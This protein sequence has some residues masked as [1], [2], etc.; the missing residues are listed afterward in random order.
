MAD[1]ILKLNGSADPGVMICQTFG[2][3]SP[4]SRRM[5]LALGAGVVV[6]ACSSDSSGSSSTD[7]P[8]TGVSDPSTP[9]TSA[10]TTAAPTT[11]PPAIELPSNPFTLG[12]ASGDPT[13]TAVILWT[14]L[15]LDPL[16]GGGMP[17]DDVDVTWEVSTTDDF[18]DVVASGTATATARHGHSVHVDAD[19]SAAGGREFH[20]RFRVG[21]HTSPTGRTLLA[22]AAGS[23]EPARVATASC[24]NWT[25]GYYTAYDDL[26][27]ERPDLLIFLGDY[28]YEGAE[29]DLTAGDAR[30]HNSAEIVDL[31]GYRNRYALY[32]TDP[33]LLAAHAV[34]PWVV[35]WDDHEVENNYANLMPEKEEEAG[36]FE[37]RRAAA[38]QAWWEHMPVRLDPPVDSGLTIYRR[39]SWGSLLNVLVL[40][41]RQYRD[42][43]ACLDLTLSLDPA[44]ADAS[45]PGRT[46]LGREQEEWLAT[47]VASDA[48]WSV[49]A[50]QTV[51]S[52]IRIGPAVLNYDQWDGYSPARD[53]VLQ[54]VVD[55][56][57][58][59]LVV[60]TGDIH[61]AGVGQLTIDDDDG[62]A[63]GVEFVTTSITSNGGVPDSLQ[64]LVVGL[65]NI[66]DAEVAHRGYTLHLISADE[67]VA[68]YRIVDDVKVEG[69]TVSTWKRFV[70]RAGS[71]NV[72]EST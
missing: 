12:V 33:S 19:L 32:R 70:V 34:C 60:L 43:Q 30:L 66:I 55:S 7:T 23:T 62:P 56:G 53:R 6:T 10:A 13:E 48:V 37:A 28:I 38:Y 68:D 44:C 36:S 26:V 72:V 71:P 57:A 29:G 49:L 64:P 40:D 61:L 35:T 52:D 47:N 45:E 41:G 46:M 58:S 15:A 65:D 31:V 25:D 59:N 8:D 14:R 21:D 63:V 54:S 9:D 5:F 20:Y 22:P 2:M 39:L 42:D 4:I 16:V 18:S 3:L 27:A 51:M 24:Q 11:T 17:D 50:Q 67:W 1:R 69:G